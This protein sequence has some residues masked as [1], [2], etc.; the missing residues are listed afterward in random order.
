MRMLWKRRKL[1]GTTHRPQAGKGAVHMKTYPVM[2][3]LIKLVSSIRFHY[4]SLFMCK[5]EYNTMIA[6][7]DRLSRRMHYYPYLN[8]YCTSSLWQQAFCSPLSVAAQNRYEYICLQ[9]NATPYKIICFQAHGHLQWYMYIQLWANVLGIFD[10]PNASR[11][12]AL[13]I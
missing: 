2:Q 8:H 5:T 12:V 6:S 3:F 10:Q 9:F 1:P 4:F 11:A 13:C 7:Q